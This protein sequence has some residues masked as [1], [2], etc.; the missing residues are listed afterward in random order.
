MPFVSRIEALEQNVQSDYV[1]DQIFEA[2]EENPTLNQT[3]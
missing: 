3:D 2:I 1:V